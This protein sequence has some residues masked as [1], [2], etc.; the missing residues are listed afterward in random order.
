MIFR[1]LKKYTAK[2]AETISQK[3]WY[4]PK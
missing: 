4:L 2:V 3:W 1:F